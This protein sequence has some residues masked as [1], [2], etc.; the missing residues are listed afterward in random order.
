MT[1]SWRA[2]GPVRCDR[3]PG[4]RSPP[5]GHWLPNHDTCRDADLLDAEPQAEAPSRMK[6]QQGPSSCPRQATTQH[7]DVAQ[8]VERP[9]PKRLVVG[10]SPAIRA[11]SPRGSAGSSGSRP[12]EQNTGAT[13]WAP[14]WKTRPGMAGR[15]ST[16]L[17]VKGPSNHRL[18]P[19]AGTCAVVQG[20]LHSDMQLPQE[21][22]GSCEGHRAP[23]RCHPVA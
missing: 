11:R 3:M 7:A 4:T 23:T 6:I 15:Y 12:P 19:D 9:S 13:R 20:E 1:C 14:D 8:L 17:T 22:H 21:P 2:S 16:G 10:S 18:Q 5:R